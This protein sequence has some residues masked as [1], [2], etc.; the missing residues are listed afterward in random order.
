MDLIFSIPYLPQILIVLAIFVAYQQIA[1]R[2]KLPSAGRGS[3]GRGSPP[4]SV[5]NMDPT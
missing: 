1:S 3:G 4:S 2:V 5:A